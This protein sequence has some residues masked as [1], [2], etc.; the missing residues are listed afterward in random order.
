[1]NNQRRK[2]IATALELLDAARI[3]SEAA[4][5]AIEEIRDEEQEAFD[6]M[7][8]SFQSGDK[9][10]VAQEAINALE[11]AESNLDGFDFESV[12]NSLEEAAA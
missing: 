6:N 1:M 8:E 2:A 10:D 11:S 5:A 4:R 7:P 12:R 3:A 9:G